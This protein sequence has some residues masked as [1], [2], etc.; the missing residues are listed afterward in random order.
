MLRGH[1]FRAHTRS[2][3]TSFTVH[4]HHSVCTNMQLIVPETCMPVS[5]ALGQCSEPWD[6]HEIVY[7]HAAD[8]W[9]HLQDSFHTCSAITG[10][11]E[12]TEKWGG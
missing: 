5:M 9:H 6:M 1:F 8:L 2:L 12:N 10:V 3:N 7:R 4:L 11:A